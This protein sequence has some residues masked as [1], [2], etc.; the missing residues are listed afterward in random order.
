MNIPGTD[1]PKPSVE[2]IGRDGNAY[3]ILGAVSRALRK[4]GCKKEVV[5]A[6]MAEAMSGDYNN[7]LVTA[8]RYVEVE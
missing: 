4:A 5:D 3:A 8:A 7:L 2:L 1:I 6:F